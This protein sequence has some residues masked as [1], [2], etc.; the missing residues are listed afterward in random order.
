LSA[1]MR[2]VESTVDPHDILFE[3]SVR[4]SLRKE[5]CLEGLLLAARAVDPAAFEQIR[6]NVQAALSGSKVGEAAANI[7]Q[8]D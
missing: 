4:L 5:R 3:M 1:P 8:E 6:E 7:A 2:E